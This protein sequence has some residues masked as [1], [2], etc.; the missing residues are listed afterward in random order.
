MCRC[1]RQPDPPHDGEELN[2][3]FSDEKRVRKSAKDA[4]SEHFAER[5][6]PQT[7]ASRF[8]D[9]RLPMARSLANRPCAE[10]LSGHFGTN[11]NKCELAVET[12]LRTNASPL[13]TACQLGAGAR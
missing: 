7:H 6:L 1:E 13:A 4:S 3:A 9:T 8:K 10:L 2:L 11:R 12:T 5:F